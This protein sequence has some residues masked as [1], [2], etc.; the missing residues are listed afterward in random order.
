MNH[1]YRELNK[2]LDS[3]NKMTVEE[4]LD[5][6]NKASKSS[7]DI[8]V[9]QDIIST[10]TFSEP[11]VEIEYQ[12]DKYIETSSITIF[13]TDKFHFSSKDSI[14]VDYLPQAA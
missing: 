8:V 7:F 3:F 14:K 4:Y 11:K 6:Y 2:L 9:E 12:K 13:E 1:G 10:V 5:L